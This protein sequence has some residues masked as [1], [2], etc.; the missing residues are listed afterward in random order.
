[1]MQQIQRLQQQ[2][3]EAQAQLAQETVTA[4]CRRRCREGHDDRRP[5]MPIG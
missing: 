2:L 5:E 3:A 4:Y 1:M